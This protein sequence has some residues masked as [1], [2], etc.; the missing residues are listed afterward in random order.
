MTPVR[1]FRG[2]RRDQRLKRPRTDGVDTTFSFPVG[3]A[4]EASVEPLDVRAAAGDE[5][6]AKTH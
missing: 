4:L 5:L 6:A 1:S 3:E 2:L